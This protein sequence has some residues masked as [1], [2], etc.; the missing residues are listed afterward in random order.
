M[1]TLLDRLILLLITIFAL[2]VVA[3]IA[4]LTAQTF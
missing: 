2:F 4:W 1:R 3:F